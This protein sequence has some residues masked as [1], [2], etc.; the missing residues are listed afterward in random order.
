MAGGPSGRRGRQAEQEAGWEGRLSQLGSTLRLT[1]SGAS[2]RACASELA[3]LALRDL[4]P[5]IAQYHPLILSSLAHAASST[6]LPTLART[7]A[8]SAARS[9]APRLLHPPQLS[10]D[11]LVHSDARGKPGEVDFKSS[12][13]QAHEPERDSSRSSSAAASERALLSDSLASTLA[14]PACPP[15]VFA[16]I[17][18]LVRDLLQS[19]AVLPE[20]L[21]IFLDRSLQL[22]NPNRLQRLCYLSLLSLVADVALA[23]AAHCSGSWRYKSSERLAS[24]EQAIIDGC[25][26]EDIRRGDEDGVYARL[27]LALSRFC[28]KDVYA[29]LSSSSHRESGHCSDSPSS[30]LLSA[31]HTLDEADG[32]ERSLKSMHSADSDDALYRGAIRAARYLR[33]EFGGCS[34]AARAT[35]AAIRTLKNGF[36]YQEGTRQKEEDHMEPE[37]SEASINVAERALSELFLRSG[38][39]VASACATAASQLT[40]SDVTAAQTVAVSRSLC[41]IVCDALA[42]ACCAQYGTEIDSLGTLIASAAQSGAQMALHDA[43][44]LLIR[45]LPL[46]HSGEHSSSVSEACWALQEQQLFG[47][48]ASHP[49]ILQVKLMRFFCLDHSARFCTING[50]SFSNVFDNALD[51]FDG[52]PQTATAVG[53][54]GRRQKERR[55]VAASASQYSAEDIGR[56]K[57]VVQSA[58]DAG[59]R[60][61]ALSQLYFL[62]GDPAVAK[63]L[64]SDEQ[65]CSLLL[66]AEE[67]CGEMVQADELEHRMALLRSLLE[68]GF[69]H[70]WMLEN[71]NRITALLLLASQLNTHTQIVTDVA[72]AIASLCFLPLLQAGVSTAVLERAFTI[73]AVPMLL[74]S[75]EGD[76][77]SRAYNQHHCQLDRV[78]EV[79]QK[80][81]GVLES[82]GFGPEEEA[83]RCLE[84]LDAANGHDHALDALGRIATA[85]SIDRDGNDVGLR[86]T[87]CMWRNHMHGVLRNSHLVHRVAHNK[88]LCGADCDLWETLAHMCKSIDFNG[89]VGRAVFR[90]ALRDIKDEAERLTNS[91]ERPA[92]A[93]PLARDNDKCESS[94]G[95]GDGD[96]WKL[97]ELGLF[98]CDQPDCEAD[99]ERLKE[100]ACDDRCAYPCRLR[101]ADVVSSGIEDEVKQRNALKPLPQNAFEGVAL[102]HRL[103]HLFTLAKAPSYTRESAAD[104]VRALAVHR[105]ASLRAQAARFLAEKAGVSVEEARRAAADSRECALT[106]MQYMRRLSQCISDIRCE[107]AM[108]VMSQS[109]SASEAADCG[110]ADASIS[111]ILDILKRNFRSG[112]L[113]RGCTA[114]LKKCSDCVPDDVL[115]QLIANMGEYSDDAAVR[116]VCELAL[117]NQKQSLNDDSMRSV[118]ERAQ[119]STLPAAPCNLVAYVLGS[120]QKSKEEST[121]SHEADWKRKLT[122]FCNAAHQAVLYAA[123]DACTRLVLAADGT[124]LFR[125]LDEYHEDD[126]HVKIG[127]DAAV[128]L[129]RA[130]MER[131]LNAEICDAL[132]VL[133]ASSDS[134][135]RAALSKDLPRRLVSG[136]DVNIQSMAIMQHMAYGKSKATNEARAALVRAGALKHTVYLASTQ[137]Q[138]DK[139]KQKAVL[140]LAANLCVGECPEVQAE[141]SAASGERAKALLKRAE[142]VRAVKVLRTLAIAS[143]SS[144]AFVRSSGP[145]LALTE[146]VKAQRSKKWS[147]LAEWLELIADI[148]LSSG[149]GCRRV[150]ELSNGSIAID[151]SSLCTATE[152]PISDSVYLAVQ[153]LFHPN[154]SSV[155]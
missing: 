114:V 47:D 29:N 145:D 25:F 136:K 77:S 55:R 82:S 128:A 1:H 90:C 20:S 103:L 83:G 27:R 41:A 78:G 75:K 123:E 107:R 42:Q 30:H 155:K 141:L 112:A 154:S 52:N 138:Q 108:E 85:V 11:L 2:A 140:E 147:T 64:A 115:N 93:H 22:S 18:H 45:L 135:K 132:C 71:M 99:E 17:V 127:E 86:K 44:D 7:S 149:A 91:G 24:F 150:L 84:T 63:A 31:L 33:W 8:A 98:C 104:V 143:G 100:L 110:E 73:E 92:L 53:R 40:H 79:L 50:Q 9:A 142:A 101:A 28:R 131:T 3:A 10:S 49:R 139:G 5:G 80:R 76:S 117:L 129:C 148:V 6:S 125:V 13:P 134:C 60:R 144:A 46:A 54:R 106:R 34:L 89:D 120:T 51:S 16:E 105:D 152:T 69:L 38:A 137:L 111:A 19:K 116:N 43:G 122:L 12:L 35:E 68:Q 37:R 153:R 81:R 67:H 96:T 57:S 70:Q 4:P 14:D 124:G 97:V 36:S 15:L 21:A 39:E 121:S 119:R 94:L 95:A 88:P 118:C 62:S 74:L 87:G 48:S 130:L 61:M 72:A 26:D 146:A 102:Q 32:L 58:A 56:L 109:H 59:V 66:W 126:E 113:V 23:S 133:L 151:L 65:L